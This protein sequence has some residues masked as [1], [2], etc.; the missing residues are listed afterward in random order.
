VSSAFTPTQYNPGSVA[1]SFQAPA[2]YQA[3]NITSGYNAPAQAMNYTSTVGNLNTSLNAPSTYTAGTYTPEKAGWNQFGTAEMQ[4]YMSPFIQGAIDPTLRAA[5]EAYAQSRAQNAA[6]MAKAGAYG[7]SRQA[8]VDAQLSQDLNTSL[9]DITGRGYQS[10]FENAQAQFERDQQ[11]RQSTEQFNINQMLEAARLGEQS[12]QFGANYGLD[13]AKTGAQ[14]QLELAKLKEMANQFGVSSALQASGDMARFGLQA[15]G[16]NEQSRQFGAGQSMTAAQLAAQQ[17]MQAQLANQAAQQAAAQLAA[18]QAQTA[19]QYD[20]QAQLANQS[21]NQF[22]AT[23]GLNALQAATQASSL[24]GRYGL[25]QYS[26]QLAGL[27]ALA[28]AGTQQQAIQQQA[29]TADYNEWLR[30]Q[31]QP[32]QM[33]E[34]E[35][36]ML[37]G[38]P[39]TETTSQSGTT[40]NGVGDLLGGI[41]DL[42]SLYRTVNSAAAPTT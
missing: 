37:Q 26:Q 16:L 1:S 5:Q 31:Q 7:G 11:R 40:S 15:A 13:F 9:S 34:F 6:R 27:S 17:D 3:S 23:Y 10:A 4:Q 35:R 8:I 2:A 24:A 39:L 32:F 20:M 12:R 28:N 29:L 22:A 18:Q 41:G 30:Q 38:L 21:A 19:A 42:L 25:D 14:Q 36:S 33:L